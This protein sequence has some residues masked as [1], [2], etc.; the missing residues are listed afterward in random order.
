MSGQIQWWAYLHTNESVHVKRYYNKAD[1]EEAL[2]SDFVKD[3]FGPFEA[4]TRNVASVIAAEHF[5]MM[6][7]DSGAYDYDEEI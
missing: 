1:L 6:I 2:E 7:Y 3:V 4:E 5:D